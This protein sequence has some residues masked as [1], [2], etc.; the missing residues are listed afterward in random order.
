MQS[1]VLAVAIT[2]AGIEFRRNSNPA[3]MPVRIDECSA[4]R[5]GS[6]LI[7]SFDL[8]NTAEKGVRRVDVAFVFEN[9]GEQRRLGMQRFA[10]AKDMEA[11]QTL[12]YAADTE[13]LRRPDV[14]RGARLGVC[15]VVGIEFADGSHLGAP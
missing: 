6:D 7:Y 1:L 9:P 4:T 12:R 13:Q 14:S 10:I 8:R 2:A 15:S 3:P 5:D 11:G